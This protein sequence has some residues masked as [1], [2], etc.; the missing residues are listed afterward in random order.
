M[1]YVLLVKHVLLVWI[2][3]KDTYGAGLLPA[4]N[5]IIVV[6]YVHANTVHGELLRREY[7]NVYSQAKSSPCVYVYRAIFHRVFPVQYIPVQYVPAAW[8]EVSQQFPV[9]PEF[10]KF[11]TYFERTWVGKRNTNPIYDIKGVDH[12][13]FFDFKMTFYHLNVFY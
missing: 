1:N 12:S 2:L 10:D 11:V 3:L 4:H 9:T 13:D 5:N 7:K 8:D 6:N